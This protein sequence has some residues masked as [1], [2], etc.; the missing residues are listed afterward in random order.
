[1]SIYLLGPKRGPDMI[2]TIRCDDCES[3][4]W[5]VL[6]S[7]WTKPGRMHTWGGFSCRFCGNIQTW[8]GEQTPSRW[9]MGWPSKEDADNDKA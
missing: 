9:V 5:V 3:L 6:R 8:D 1:M 4:N 7:D 2:R